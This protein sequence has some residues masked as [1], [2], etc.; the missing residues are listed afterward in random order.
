MVMQA[1]CVLPA[2]VNGFGKASTTRSEKQRVRVDG[3]EHVGAIT[4]FAN[5]ITSFC[6]SL[7]L[8]E[9]RVLLYSTRENYPH[10]RRTA[11]RNKTWLKSC[12]RDSLTTVLLLSL[13]L[14]HHLQHHQQQPQQHST[15]RVLALMSTS[16]AVHPLTQHLPI[17]RATTA[18]CDVI[19][20]SAVSTSRFGGNKQGKNTKIRL[21]KLHSRSR[22]GLAIA[23]PRRRKASAERRGL[24]GAR[25]RYPEYKLVGTELPC[26]SY[27]VSCLAAAK[28]TIDPSTATN[29]KP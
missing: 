6:T 7:F 15:L 22:R 9:K 25:K 23:D 27:P 1:A 18:A 2:R 19:P 21:D 29:V 12:L 17:P 20:P 3:Q 11:Q 26:S 10:V 13:F 5:V 16:A 8:R 28:R 4:F 14:P 24:D